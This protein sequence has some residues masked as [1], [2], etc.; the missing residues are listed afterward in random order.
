MSDSP[1]AMTIGE[2]CAVTDQFARFLKGLGR[3]QEAAAAFRGV[4]QLVAERTAAAEKLASGIAIA[5][6]NLESLS[7]RAA[8]MKTDADDL[9]AAARAQAESLL[10][11]AREQA[12]KVRADAEE[13]A[14]SARADAQAHATA[15]DAAVK[16]KAAAEAELADLNERIAQ[17]REA[18]RTAFGG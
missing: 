8:Q 4:E 7:A 17:A 5:Q 13:S 18:A 15:A 3:L 1:D 6:A 14:A 12:N 9:V 2:A 11:V 10:E 16:A